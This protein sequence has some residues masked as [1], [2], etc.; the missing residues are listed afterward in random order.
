M[1]TCRRPDCAHSNPQP[2]TNFYKCK[3]NVSDG[4]MSYCKKCFMKHYTAPR[5]KAEH[6]AKQIAK[7]K[8]GPIALADLPGEVWKDIEGYD[9]IQYKIS[10]AGRVKRVD[11]MGEKLMS[12][13]L[14]KVLNYWQVN[15]TMEFRTTQH[16]YVHR[17]LA[18]AFIPNPLGYTDVNHKDGV[19]HNNDLT[20][21]EWC[22][23]KMNTH[24]AIHE[25]K[26]HAVV[27]Q[28]RKQRQKLG[29]P[30]KVCAA[31]RQRKDKTNFHRDSSKLD[32]LCYYCKPCSIERS[33]ASRSRNE[34][35]T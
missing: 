13:H 15:L 30:T 33:S 18:K 9:Y 29:L 7:N 19:R 22:S 3:R 23:P 28:I 11:N 26:K 16:E 21:L 5:N 4:L 17:L 34:P 1:K 14:N 31:C 35:K 6:L 2:L 12:P 32:G 8:R 10:S 24:H 25:L 27:T 20:N